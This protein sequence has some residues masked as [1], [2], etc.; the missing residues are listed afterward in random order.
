MGRIVDGCKL[1]SLKLARR[2]P[3]DPEPVVGGLA[4][5]WEQATGGLDAALA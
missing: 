4:E 2:R 5:A 3:F 1:L